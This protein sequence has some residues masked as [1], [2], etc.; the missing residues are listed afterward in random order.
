MRSCTCLFYDER[1]FLLMAKGVAEV[2]LRLL[3]RRGRMADNALPATTPVA[4][5]L[6]VPALTASKGALALAMVGLVSSVAVAQPANRSVNVSSVHNSDAIREIASSEI[7]FERLEGHSST[8]VI[9]A[10]AGSADGQ[11]VAAAGDDHAIRIIRIETGETVQTVLGHED[12]IQSLLFAYSHIGSK[13]PLHNEVTED[14]LEPNFDAT[15][16]LYS[17]GHDGRILRW[18]FTFPLEAQEIAIVP[19]AV[20]SIS[21][22][23]EKQLL[24][25]GGFSEEVLLFDLAENQY[26]QRLKCPTNDQRCVRFSPD[27]SRVLSGSRD[28]EILAWDTA[29]GELLARYREHQS[30][31]QTAAFSADSTLITSAGEDRRVVRYDIA[32][33]QVVWNHQIAMSKLR[34]LCLINDHIVAVAGADNGIRLFDAQTNRIVAEMAGH[35]GTVAVMA[36]C[37]DSLASGSFDTTVRIWNLN[38]LEERRARKSIPTSRT[39]IKMDSQ[40]QIR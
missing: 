18:R 12:W 24:A 36:P 40:L 16:D 1:A 27:G 39:P 25:I 33:Q 13:A 20:R 14:A 28:G 21:V 3:S 9:T 38:E 8:P 30:R 7:V 11:Y 34:S 22:S 29:T 26:V 35:L 23:S 6:V 32:Q 37:G 5:H 31:I 2:F 15:T 19:Y 4:Q 10:L 17:A